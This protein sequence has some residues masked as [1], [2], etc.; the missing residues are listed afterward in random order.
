M[1]DLVSDFPN[2]LTKALEIGASIQKRTAKYAIQNIVITGLGGS[3]IGGK[4]VSQLVAEKSQVPIL[5]NNDYGIPNFVNQHTLVIACSY[6]G[7]TEETIEAVEKA[8]EQG[9]EIFCVT[10]GG[11]I[12]EMANANGFGL[13]VIPGGLP[14]RAALGYSMPQLFGVLNAYSII[15][16]DYV[17]STNQ[18]IA[19]I[20]K[21]EE[22]IKTEAKAVAGRL[23]GKMPVIYADAKFEGLIT[24]FR[25][26]LNENSKVL[27]WHHVLPEMNH[28]ELVGWAGADDNVAVILIQSESDYYR[29][30]ERFA[31]SKN[32][33][34]KHTTNI[35]EINAKGEDEIQRTLY[36]IHLTDWVSV[37]LAELRKV[38]PIEV[39]IITSLKSKLAD[40]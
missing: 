19:L 13:L 38:D 20:R 34:Q 37:Y 14:P 8:H 11:K 40:L 24:R 17:V 39:N 16:G 6:S 28:N 2:Q 31:F 7:N 23:N 9:A 36:L 26:Q 25:Q 35:S 27:C 4:I 5:T 32:V 21:E 15:D 30:T 1:K 3:G 29:T 18:A 22:N 12:E 33:F 10:S